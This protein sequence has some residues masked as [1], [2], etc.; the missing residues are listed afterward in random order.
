MSCVVVCIALA[1]DVFRGGICP[2]LYIRG[3]R[4]TWKV[5]AEY[6]WSPATARSDSIL[7]TAAS[8]TLIQVVT[9]TTTNMTFCDEY[10]MTSGLFVVMAVCFVTF[11][12]GQYSLVTKM[13]CPSLRSTQNRHKQLLF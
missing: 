9:S 13:S 6:S 3:D 12:I 1:V 4:F 2:P 8:S 11:S 7:C 5:L 10:L